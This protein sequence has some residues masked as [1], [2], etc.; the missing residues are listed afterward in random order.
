MLQNSEIQSIHMQLSPLSRWPLFA[1]ATLNQF[2]LPLLLM[3]KTGDTKDIQSG[4]FQGSQ[5]HFN[6]SELGAV[7]GLFDH[8]DDID[9]FTSAMD[10]NFTYLQ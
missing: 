2:L 7:I 10:R 3:Y 5:Q 8:K 4:R 1:M 6:G 9:A